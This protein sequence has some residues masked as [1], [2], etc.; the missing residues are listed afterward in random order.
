M[1]CYSSIFCPKTIGHV[2]YKARLNQNNNGFS[3]ANDHYD[4]RH[5]QSLDIYLIRDERGNVHGIVSPS[6]GDPLINSELP[7]PMDWPPPYSEDLSGVPPPPYE[8]SNN[9]NT[10][11]AENRR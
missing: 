7:R 1:L 4:N 2:R 3:Q 5:Q 11:S 8:D 6:N 9:T 10:N